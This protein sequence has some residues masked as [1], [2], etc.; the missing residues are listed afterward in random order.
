MTDLWTE[1]T[2]DPQQE[3]LNEALSSA[4]EAL[5]PKFAFVLGASSKHEFEDRMALVS[6][7]VERVVAAATA[8][9]PGLFPV[10]HEAVLTQWE[11]DFD[12][13]AG[14]RAA[15]TQRKN[16][17][18][19]YE[20][21]VARGRQ[22][23][24]EAAYGY[25]DPYGDTCE[26]CGK[27]GC[28]PN[29]PGPNGGSTTCP[30]CGG[31]AK[32]HNGEVKCNDP[33]GCGYGWSGSRREYASRKQAI[34]WPSVEKSIDAIRQIVT[35][36]S[37]KKIDGV[38]VDATTA[39]AIITVY[40]ALNDE[41]KAKFAALPID[42]MGDA[43]WK[44]L[45]KNSSRKTAGWDDLAPGT[46]LRLGFEES[47]FDGT[48]VRIEHPY[49]DHPIYGNTPVVVYTDDGGNERRYLLTSY[50]GQYE[51]PRMLA[52]RKQAGPMFPGAGAHVYY[53]EA[54][55][56]TGWDEG[57]DDEGSSGDADDEDYGEVGDS[58]E[59]RLDRESSR[60]Q[61]TDGWQCGNC[62]QFNDK[63]DVRCRSCGSTSHTASAPKLISSTETAHLASTV[64]SF[65]G[66]I[67]WAVTSIDGEREFAA[68]THDSPETAQRLSSA[69]ARRLEAK[70]VWVDDEDDEDQDKTE[71]KSEAAPAEQQ[72]EAPAQPPQEEAP[73][74]DKS[75]DKVPD[76]P[77]VEQKPSEQPPADQ[78]QPPQQADPAQ[79]VDPAV[80]PTDAAPESQDGT[81][82]GA[83]RVDDPTSMEVGQ[84]T[85]MSYVMAGGGNGSVEVTFVREDNGIFYFNG[86]TGEFGVAQREGKWIDAAANEFTFGAN[87]G[88]PEE[89]QG[90]VGAPTATEQ[91]E[92]APD[93]PPA[94]DAPPSDSESDAPKSEEG[95]DDSDAK[96]K[97]DEK[98]DDEKKDGPPWAKKSSFSGN[99]RTVTG[100]GTWGSVTTSSNAWPGNVNV[101]YT[102]GGQ[103]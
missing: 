59:D 12:D 72:Q 95:G 102:H 79:P 52:S 31:G 86:P 37:A 84:S 82:E 24:V 15:Q 34:D 25:S 96:P 50:Q 65:A 1:A 13:L 97:D 35:D 81:A 73:E 2:R 7:Q 27:E 56:P 62:G 43:A 83:E 67:H 88:A 74:P 99:A 33:D 61:A 51:Q 18:R 71:D 9:D 89:G 68:G 22:V 85:T 58:W 103:S 3:R 93:A 29:C 42:R 47:A 28:S 55:E 40:D 87:A 39:N 77:P 30:K 76:T 78:P 44:L 4:H 64:V 69:L 5:A 38:F 49:Q 46:R 41:N 6:D 80:T 63:S 92:V 21:Q 23:S 20:R 98:D 11:A 60:K 17:R 54:G 36:H 53:N 90:Q 48:F 14:L 101:T 70:Y 91:Q 57:G 100:N 19:A 45:S 26:Y 8:N 16:S 10:V 32:V 75:V 94:K 66:K